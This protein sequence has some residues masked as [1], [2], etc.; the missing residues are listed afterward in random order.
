MFNIPP[1]FAMRSWKFYA[2]LLSLDMVALH[3][4]VIPRYLRYIARIIVRFWSNIMQFICMHLSVVYFIFCYRMSDEVPT[5][6]SVDFEVHFRYESRIREYPSA[7]Y[8]NCP[9]SLLR[10]MLNWAAIHVVD[11]WWR[12]NLDENN[13]IKV[14]TPTICAITGNFVLWASS[15]VRQ[16]ALHYNLE[17]MAS[18][19]WELEWIAIKFNRNNTE[20]PLKFAMHLV[21]E[22]IRVRYAAVTDIFTINRPYECLI[23]RFRVRTPNWIYQYPCERFARIVVKASDKEATS[24]RAD[25]IRI[26]KRALKKASRLG[27]RIADDDENW[28]V[29]ALPHARAIRIAMS[30]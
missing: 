9:S 24:S 13:Y 2:I 28:L 29:Y 7:S 11:G 23:Q 30:R 25:A 16:L 15:L 20:I 3:S 19:T 8:S 22:I 12:L 26:V 5:I 10:S 6:R 18:P 1:P 27:N 17:V 4:P 14:H 21:T